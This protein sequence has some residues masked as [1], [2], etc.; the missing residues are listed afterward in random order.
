MKLA[1][2]S[3]KLC[4][5]S[6]SSPTGFSTDGGFPFQIE[7]ISELFDET[8]VVVPSESV[9]SAGLAPL[10]GRGMRVVALST[11][12][13]QGGSRKLRFPFW[14]LKNGP[15]IWKSVR[16]SDAVHTPIPGDV[17]T[18][19]MLFALLLRKPLFVRHC[20]N[21]LVQRTFA[22]HFWKWSME[23]FGGGRNVMFA[24]GGALEG[25]SKKNPSIKWIFSTSLRRS[26]MASTKSRTLPDDGRIR[27][28][29]ASRQEPRKGTDV[30]IES[31]PAILE[32][33]PHAT[34]D[35]IGDGSLLPELRQLAAKL[36]VSE[37]ITFHG[38]IE[39][40]NVLDLF[41]RGHLFCYPTSAS[42][43]FPKVVLEAL[44]A[45]MPVITTRVSVLPQLIGRGCGTLLESASP[46]E[47]I[48]NVIN[49][50]S[51][52]ARYDE[53]SEKA[54]EISREYCLENWRDT[55]GE[56]LCAAWGKRSLSGG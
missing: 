37:S 43:G 53:M 42:E 24:T 11:P 9:T 51:N 23:F 32:S 35:V 36:G 19:G 26:Q 25:P 46:D 18:I 30:M 1:V 7:A 8:T 16:E 2:V 44:A 4:W 40:S 48:A 33:L 13:G 29:I 41:R 55:I 45:G 50:C 6:S 5:P 22:E 49:A 20:G 3:H 17:G 12:N 15:T 10:T 27:L 54:V 52:E 21:W 56:T 34:L 39:H 31:M 38:K 28:I 14:V 47:M